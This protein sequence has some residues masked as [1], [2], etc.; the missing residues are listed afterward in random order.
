[1]SSSFTSTDPAIT[2]A[3]Q[4]TLIDGYSADRVS[5]H[6]FVDIVGSDS[7]DV[8][9]YPAGLRSG[10]IVAVFAVEADAHRLAD[11]LAGTYPVEFAST[12]RPVL[13]MTFLANG[14]ITV[15][16]DDQTREVWLVTTQFQEVQA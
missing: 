11:W 7:Q 14:R 1:M 8:Y 3:V 2:E 15:A 9:V 6:R 12:E 5:R 13:D 10:S 16:L 4:P